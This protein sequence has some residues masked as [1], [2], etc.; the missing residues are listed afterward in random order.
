MLCYVTAVVNGFTF[1]VP[2]EYDHYITL[3]QFDWSCLLCLFDILPPDDG[4]DL[5]IVS[6]L[7]D[8]QSHLDNTLL[9][10]LDIFEESLTAD[11]WI[12]H[13]NVHGLLSKFTEIGQWLHSSHGSNIIVC[14]SET[15]LQGDK[16]PATPGFVSYCSPLLERPTG[17]RLLPG[18]CMFIFNTLIPSRPEICVV[19]QSTTCS[20]VTC[21][22]VVF[23]HGQT[24]VL[25]VYRSP[26][27]CYKTTINELYSIL[28]Q[29]STYVKY[30][31]VAGDFNIDLQSSLSIS[32]EYRCLLD[33]FCLTHI[34]LHLVEYVMALPL[35]LITF[36]VAT[37][38]LLL[39]HVK[40]L[41]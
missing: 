17:K 8:S 29:L 10:P 14:C 24:A 25:S 41:D 12:V 30:F 21:C 7:F 2:E 38:F 16:L 28:L 4:C 40:Q 6:T 35:L 31:I 37:N 22:F 1:S 27:T 11:L 13:H 5:S 15:W 34:L 32:K 23:N 3:H 18:S 33:D 26:S 39:A 9:L 19:E 36:L 20:N